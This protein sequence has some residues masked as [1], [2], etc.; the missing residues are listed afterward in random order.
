MRYDFDAVI[1][2]RN[3][4]SAK[5]DRNQELFGVEEVLDMWVADMDLP[6][7]E[8]VIRALKERLEHPLFG[9][10][11]PQD[12]LYQAVIDRMKRF[13]GWE[14]EREWILF[15]P[16]VVSALYSCIEAL[17]DPGDEIILQP[18]VYYP[19]FGAVRN[20][21]RHVVQ[22]QLVYS[23]GQ[24]SMDLEG[25]E[26]CFVDEQGFGARTHRIRAL[27]LCSPHNPVG[28]VWT[29]E[30]LSGLAE[31]CLN[32]DCAIISDEIH[33]DLLVGD[34]AHTVTATLSPEV[35]RN[36]IT[37]MAP[38]K[39]FNLASLGASFAIVPREDWRQQIQKVRLGQSGV[40][41]LGLVAMEAALREGDD[42][43]RQ[44]NQYLRGNVE[45]F[46]DRTREIPGVHTIRPEGTYLIWVD[47]RDLGMDDLELREFM[48]KEVGVATDF[49]YVFGSGGEGF[50]RFNLGCPR[51]YVEKALDSL[52]SAVKRIKG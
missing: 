52:E 6:C 20:T 47:M 30:E 15:I 31:I 38:S 28:R 3:T 14:V 8:P 16:G 10:T 19:F 4:G 2:R 48:L 49:G 1:E 21:G 42:Y 11:F 23:G 35:A 13:Y 24:Y 36:T 26:E 50:Q 17:S 22:N 40:N 46:M 41:A 51:I 32:R 39:T 34:R 5:W 29:P 37:L 44:L 43:L 27:V 45:Y 12:S 7:P 18:P 33:G 9:Y 25:L